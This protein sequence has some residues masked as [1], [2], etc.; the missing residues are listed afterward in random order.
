MLQPDGQLKISVIDQG[1]G[2]SPT[3]LPQLF[4]AFAQADSST[5][6]HFGG[7][8]LGLY[9]SQQ[10]AEAMQMTIEVH[11]IIG[12]GA[13]FCLLVPAHLLSD[14]PTTWQAEAIVSEPSISLKPAHILVVD[15]V[16]DI[17]ALIASYLEQQPLQISFA[18]DGLAALNQCQQQVFDLIIMDQ[19]MPELDGFSAAKK[20]RELGCLCP[21]LSLSADV[22]EDAD[23]QLSAVFNLTM[24]KP[25][26]KQ[27]LLQAIA[28]LQ[29]GESMVVAAIQP[30]AGQQSE[31]TEPPEDE[32]L[33]EYRQTLPEHAA[34][35][36]Q[37]A[38]AN[39]QQALRRLLH[40]IKGTSAC[41][42][43]TEVSALA[44]QAEQ[45]LKNTGTATDSLEQLIT[46]LQ[47]AGLN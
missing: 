4:K 36:R 33:L 12:E 22:F 13:E 19:Q 26:S 7:T 23:K 6:R 8:G 47:Q 1:I 34:R 35:I 25:F 29:T 39:D 45:L 16:A 38:A 9:I 21:I 24:T 37:L 11:S 46:V 42:G 17:R 28:Q 44:L 30:D 3:Q 32:L 15:D 40:Q 41:F 20:I 31:L 18:A 27:L 5:S 14:A 10:L 43:L 2:I